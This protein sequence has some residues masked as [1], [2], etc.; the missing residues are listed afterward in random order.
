M[1]DG[2]SQHETRRSAPYTMRNATM[3]KTLA[4]ALSGLAG[5]GLAACDRG[6][7]SAPSTSNAGTAV[8]K[9]SA[10]SAIAA[11]SATPIDNP[12]ELCHQART[13]SR[14]LYVDVGA[15]WKLMVNANGKTQS[16]PEIAAAADK[17]NSTAAEVIPQLEGIV[18]TGAP[19]DIGDAVREYT[20]AAKSFTDS[21][22]EGAPGE[23]QT[24]LA[25]KYGDAVDKLNSVCKAG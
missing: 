24:P 25:S 8:V 1:D 22:G 14:K 16:D 17:V 12:K 13:L 2:Q 7:S 10:S 23:E 5:L 21:I 11:P 9:P 18:G 3:T 4:L 15:Y 6:G 20:S 19:S